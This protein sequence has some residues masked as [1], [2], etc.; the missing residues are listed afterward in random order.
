[1]CRDCFSLTVQLCGGDLYYGGAVYNSFREFEVEEYEDLI[2]TEASKDLVEAAKNRIVKII[3]SQMATP[4]VGNE[5]ALREISSMLSEIFTESDAKIIR[6]EVLS[7]NYS[8]AL[9]KREARMVFEN[10]VHSDAYA[11]S[12][13]AKKYESWKTYINFEVAEKE[14]SRAERL[15]QRALLAVPSCQDLWN[16][17]VQFTAFVLKNMAN[18][19]ALTEKALRVCPANALFHKVYILAVEYCSAGDVDRITASA[20]KA[21]YAGLQS[22]EDY[23][24]ILLI[25]CDYYFRQ[26]RKI[27]S[28]S[29][30]SAKVQSICDS[31]HQSFE[32]VAGTLR[33][34]YPDWIAA[35]LRVCKYQVATSTFAESISSSNGVSMSSLTSFD[36][37]NKIVKNDTWENLVKFPSCSKQYSA[38]SEY[39]KW[40][41]YSKG[42]YPMGRAVYKRAAAAVTDYQVE[43][44]K[45][46]YQF[47]CMFGTV[48][49]IMTALEKSH[50]VEAAAYAVAQA[51]VVNSVAPT[52]TKTVAKRKLDNHDNDNGGN[53]AK[54]RNGPQKSEVTVSER[55]PRASASAAAPA[56]TAATAPAPAPAPATGFP[57]KMVTISNLS[58]NL[59]EEEAASGVMGLLASSPLPAMMTSF[60]QLRQLLLV[61]LVLSKT[62]KSRGLVN[63]QLTAVENSEQ[64][65]AIVSHVAEVLNGK[66]IGER[67][68]KAEVV[69][70]P[71]SVGP[72]PAANSKTDDSQ[73]HPT[74]VFVSKLPLTFTNEDLVA[75]FTTC[76]QI[77]ASKINV[78]K[79]T[80]ESKVLYL[81]RLI[82]LSWSQYF[83]IIGSWTC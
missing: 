65:Q 44:C 67:A 34:Y 24:D 33:S 21:L 61:S 80:Q 82:V 25:P 11:E 9:E 72:V 28:S 18:T 37:N 23:L 49:E 81:E 48:S 4:L 50:K 22:V 6:P 42:D 76:G 60:D 36:T 71:R 46:W 63:I 30:P 27:A 70:D 56:T 38:W 2:D 40:A 26:L 73:H 5:R 31:L 74:A 64:E 41:T 68:V 3:H 32:N 1:V 8:A 66:S 47:E 14:L 83:L 58:F 29:S 19:Q 62:G 53:D 16:D 77:K 51:A 79:K 55:I 7:K 59:P 54:R 57:S 39:A 78:D 35:H 17:A 43:M 52:E 15:Y 12:V 10:H 13:D 20:N 45:E 69:D 75:L